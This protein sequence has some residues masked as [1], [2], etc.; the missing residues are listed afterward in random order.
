MKFKHFL[1]LFI[2]ILLL[3]SATNAHTNDATGDKGVIAGKV[4]DADNNKP[5]EF[6]TVS[7]FGAKDSTL[8][9]GT[10]TSAEGIFYL[11]K[12][13]MGDYY[14]QTRFIGYDPEIRSVQLT[15]EKPVA[16]LDVISIKPSSTDLGEMVITEEKSEMQTMIDKKV[17][18]VEKNITSQ[19]GNGLDV[20]RN[21]PSVDVD[22]DDNITL[23]GDQNVTILID[24][25][26]SSLPA[27]Q[28]LK[29][30]PSSAIEKVEVVTNPSAKYDPEGMSGILNIVLKKNKAVGMNGSLN[31]SSGYGKYGKYN[32]TLGLNYRKNKLNIYTNYN[33]YNG[34]FWYGGEID[35]NFL[36]NDS[37]YHQNTKDEGNYLSNSHWG[38]AGFDYFLNDN[39]TV[40]L[41]VSG[42][43]NKGSGTRAIDY[44]SLGPGSEL[45][46]YSDRIADS[47]NPNTN[48]DLNGG[49]QMKFKNPEHTFDIDLNYTVSDAEAIENS[50]QNF[51]NSDASADGNPTAQNTTTTNTSKLLYIRADYTLPI[52]DS[53]KF[54][55]GFHSTGRDIESG[56]YS[57][58]KDPLTGIFSA[59]TSLNNDFVYDQQVFAA[60]AIFGQQRK[61]FGYQIGLR[62]EQ[63]LVDAELLTTNETF[64]NDYFTLFPSGHFSYKVKEK[65]EFQL[66]YSRRIN[67]PELEELNP[68]TSYA[69]PYTVQSGN[70]FLKPEFIHVTELSYMRYWDKVTLN[71]S[72]YY[73]II[74]DQKRRYLDLTDQG[75][76]VVSYDNLSQGTVTG[77]ELIFGYNPVKWLRTNTTVNFF[78]T[79]ISDESLDEGLQ[80][81]TSGWNAQLSATAT[82]KKGWMIQL[83]GRYNGKMEVLQG[84][85]QPMGGLDVAIRKPVLQ[86]RGSIG[87]RA[88]DVLGT[89]RFR[90][91]SANLIDYSFYTNR[92]WESQTVYVTFNYFFGKMQAGPQRRRLKDKSAGDD[93]DIPDMQ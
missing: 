89:R 62:A 69:D 68:F 74:T 19:G 22:V 33:Y 1:P 82:L 26:P 34:N 11:D 81:K 27:S 83:N 66:S 44:E 59:D 67:R 12:L 72:T 31:L 50:T 90:F 13:P 88:S 93:L 78:Q 80:L 5:V 58:S 2:S 84:T 91:D 86:K 57:E 41:S 36:L 49:W 8:I 64:N 23:R 46:S 47:E 53:S 39:N 55:A 56:F 17:F 70:P 45:L 14:I 20:L 77:A 4:M 65:N 21:V 9:T 16:N 63:T 15:T 7:L 18:N 24:G 73:R 51:F 29:Q 43:S 32:G 6:A 76:S 25:R 40:Y 28:L 79:T 35:R 92:L 87:V 38:K 75:V 10:I 61:K 71:A 54:E 52:G 85:I 60:Y 30:L 42:S 3:T 48:M 37:A